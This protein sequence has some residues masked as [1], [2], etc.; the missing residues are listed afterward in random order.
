MEEEKKK[1]EERGK[2][3]FTPEERLVI[4]KAAIEIPKGLKNGSIQVENA[5]LKNLFAF[6]RLKF[7]GGPDPP[8]LPMAAPADG[9]DPEPG[10]EANHEVLKQEDSITGDFSEELYTI[11][12]S[13][14]KEL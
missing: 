2:V 13:A 6:Q 14:A 1:A 5:D 4:L 9:A 11:F 8:V 10:Y 12:E 7:Y 3:E